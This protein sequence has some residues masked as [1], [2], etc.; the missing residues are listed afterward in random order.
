MFLQP[1]KN[2]YQIILTP[3]PLAYT[4]YNKRWAER[5]ST[6]DRVK[7]VLKQSQRHRRF[8]LLIVCTQM[9]KNFSTQIQIDR[10]GALVKKEDLLKLI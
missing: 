3:Q 9:K 1:K 7:L 2:I 10:G 4:I 6:N 5:E 8:D